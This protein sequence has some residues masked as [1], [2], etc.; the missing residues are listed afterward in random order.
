MQTSLT[1]NSMSFLVEQVFSGSPMLL[2][3]D[4]LLW[5]MRME[6]MDL[7]SIK[8]ARPQDLQDYLVNQQID[9]NYQVIA[10][11]CGGNCFKEKNKNGIIRPNCSLFCVSNFQLER[12]QISV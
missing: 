11:V 4:S 1:L 7:V 5:G 8:G 10:V 12:L 6:E 3:G 9:L 2:L